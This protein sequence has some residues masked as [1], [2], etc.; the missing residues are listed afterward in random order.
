M[1]FVQQHHITPPY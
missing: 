1:A